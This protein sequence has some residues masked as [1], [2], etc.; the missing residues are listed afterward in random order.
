[1]LGATR[2]RLLKTKKLLSEGTARPS[3]EA[4]SR[5]RARSP[6]W[7]IRLP[8][9]LR[10]QHPARR[11]KP[12]SPRCRQRRWPWPHRSQWLLWQHLRQQLRRRPFHLQLR[13]CCHLSLHRWLHPCQHARAGC[14]A[15]GCSGCCTCGNTFVRTRASASGSYTCSCASASCSCGCSSCCDKR[16]THG[17]GC[18]SACRDGC[19]DFTSCCTG[20][21][22]GP[23]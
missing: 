10:S 11:C 20:P 14:R 9:K 18:S 1:M 12:G 13:R 3:S 15:G 16:G 19:R 17:R 8:R 7:P 23:S 2:G 6:S 5:R 21:N 4:R 22:S